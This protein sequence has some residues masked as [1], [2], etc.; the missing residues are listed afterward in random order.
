MSVRF[1]R[2]I[3][4]PDV[5]LSAI[6]LSAC[7]CGALARGLEGGVCGRCGGA[8]LNVKE[9]KRLEQEPGFNLLFRKTNQ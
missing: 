1:G 9:R 2:L 5:G 8:V 4:R 6:Q 3:L 7:A